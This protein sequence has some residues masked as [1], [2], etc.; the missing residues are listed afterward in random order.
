[1]SLLTID[2]PAAPVHH[3]PWSAQHPVWALGFRPFYILTAAFAALAVPLWLAQ[4]V[5]WLS[6]PHGGLGWHAHEMVYGMAIA[7]IVGFLF[8]AGRA[9]TNLWT[10]RGAHL[11]ALAGVWLA[12]RGAMLAAPPLAAAA[13]DLLFLPLAA[14]PLYRVLKQSGNKRNL[15]LVFLLGLLTVANALFHAATLGWIAMSPLTPVH[16]AIL[17]IVI[18]EAVIGGRVIPM[19]TNNGAPGSKPV[20]RPRYDRVALGLT[21]AASIAYVLALPGAISAALMMAAACAMLVRLAGWQPQRTLHVPLLW[22]LHVG[23]AWIAL[24]FALL[25]LAALGFGTA[26]AGFHALAVGSMAGLIIGMMTRTTLGHTGRILKTGRYEPLMYLLIQAG[27]VLRVLAQFIPFEWRTGALL[28]SGVCW[29]LSF[30]LFLLV[31]TPYL[32]RARI[33]GREG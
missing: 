20:V 16:A 19:F 5:G 32:W 2:E 29:S 31:Y 18:I 30:L 17:V 24:G 13:V 7:V 23:Y 9:W 8:T 28:A 26:S 22:I 12:G 15:F 27:A 14:W 10:P 33:D 3:A 11:A 25:S 4:Y 21:V 6:W 1:M